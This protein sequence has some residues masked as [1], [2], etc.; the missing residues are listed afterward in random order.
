M[1][2]VVRD[3]SPT[4]TAIQHHHHGVSFSYHYT[5]LLVP[6]HESDHISVYMT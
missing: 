2:L 5:S 1:P 6:H 3:L 4:N